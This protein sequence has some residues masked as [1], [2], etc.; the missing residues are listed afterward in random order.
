MALRSQARLLRALRTMLMGDAREALPNIC[1]PKPSF[2]PGDTG[3]PLP[4]STPEAEGIRSDTLLAFYKDIAAAPGTNAHALLVLRNGKVISEG[5]F[6][7]YRRDVWHVTHSLCKSFVGTAVGLAVQEGLFAPDDT[8]ANYFRDEIGFLNMGRFKDKTVQHLLTMSS[9]ITLNEISELV[10]PNWL[11]GIFNSA[12]AFQPGS[13]FVYNS[14]NSYLLAALVCK[15]SGQS[16]LDYLRPRIF[17]PMGFGPVGWETSPEGIEKGGWGMYMLVED[18]AKLGQLYLQNGQWRVGGQ[19]RQLLPQAWVQQATQTQITGE[20]GEEYG[21]QIWTDA[22]TGAYMMNGMFGQYVTVIPRLNIV[23]AMT[24]GNPHLLTDSAA[25]TLMQNHFWPLEAGKPLR[26]NPV[27]LGRLRRAMAGLTYRQPVATSFKKPPFY[28]PL[29]RRRASAKLLQNGIVPPEMDAF[30]GVTWKF[31]QHEA[32]FLPLI[33]QGMNNNFS[34]GV[35]ALR[36]ENFRD[37]LMLYWEEDDI[38]L[39]VPF[40]V[41]QAAERTVVIN[42]ESFLLGSTAAL[43]QNEDGEDVLVLQ[44]CLL[45]HSSSRVIK[46]K[47]RQGVLYMQL[48]EYPQLRVALE[49]AVEQNAATGGPE[50]GAGPDSIEKFVRGSSYLSYR[51]AQLC[52]PTATATPVSE[53]TDEPLP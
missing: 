21:Y 1:G 6:S 47:I 44:A 4:R 38:T 37:T 40:G 48:D 51:I 34:G 45:E 23:I 3:T 9:G 31:A 12:V 39:C 16:L 11:R 7:P 35:V 14:M 41:G 29:A 24:A 5:Y 46:L 15:T 30:C 42:G 36:L 10:E 13:R 2:I 52:T 18:M 33:V 28:R 27:A 32:S 26:E 22:Q 19:P 43:R 20:Q 53:E 25:Y 17:E 50:A 49:K 8:I